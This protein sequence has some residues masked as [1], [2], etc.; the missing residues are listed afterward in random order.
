MYSFSIYQWPVSLLKRLEQFSRNFIWTGAFD[1]KSCVCPSYEDMCK[2]EK[3]GGLGIWCLRAMNKVAVVK[4]VLGWL[5]GSDEVSAFIRLSTKLTSSGSKLKKFSSSLVA[6]GRSTASVLQAHT[7]WWVGNGTRIDFWTDNWFGGVIT[8]HLV[9]PD[10]VTQKLKAKVADFIVQGHWCIP[11]VFKENFPLLAQ[12]I[13]NV[14]FYN[15]G[16]ELIWTSSLTT[17]FSRYI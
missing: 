3:E 17:H 14:D 10:S 15:R 7:L 4:S 13:S 9:L 1:K 11:Q 12:R 6:G 8:D 2:P 5:N 16:D